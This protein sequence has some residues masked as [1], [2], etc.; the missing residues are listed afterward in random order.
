M[1]L[2]GGFGHFYAY[3]PSKIGYAIDRFAIEVKRQL[4][5]LD[6][7]LAAS[8]YLA[9]A[10]YTIADMAVWAWYGALVKGEV[11]NAGESLQVES[12]RHV[13]E[14]AAVKRGG[15]EDAVVVHEAHQR[16]DVVVVPGAAFAARVAVVTG[17]VMRSVLVSMRAKG[18]E[19]GRRRPGL[20]ESP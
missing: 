17:E 10:D 3:A 13:G 8:A 16:V 14:R 7:R 9:G 4:D 19:R 20:R 6:R 15:L 1:Y 11:Y 5:V 18:N 12:Y 2:G